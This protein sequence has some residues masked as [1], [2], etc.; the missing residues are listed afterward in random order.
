MNEAKLNSREAG[1]YLLA[2]HL[3]NIIIY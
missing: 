2:V 1:P 3:S